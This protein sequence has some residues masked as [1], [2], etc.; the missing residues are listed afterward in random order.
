MARDGV[1][2]P[3]LRVHVQE[4]ARVGVSEPDRRPLRP[5]LAGHRLHDPVVATVG[6]LREAAHL[7]AVCEGAPVEVRVEEPLRVDVL[8]TD[9]VPAADRPPRWTADR[10]T[11][12]P[13]D[14]AS[15][16]PISVGYTLSC[17]GVMM[18]VMVCSVFS[19]C[20]IVSSEPTWECGDH[21]LSTAGPVLH[22]LREQ[23]GLGGHVSQLHDR[24]ASDHGGGAT[25]IVGAL[26]R[27]QGKQEQEQE[28]NQQGCCISRCCHCR[29]C[30]CR[31]SRCRHHCRSRAVFGFVLFGRAAETP[32]PPLVLDSLSTE[33][34]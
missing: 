30:R 8:Q 14:G 2:V 29:C 28:E 5:P 6:P 22:L 7:L 23:H 25:A 15:N 21:L 1:P 10:G 31:Y 13:V 20:A 12:L 27:R 4:L 34:Q 17:V 19:V 26:H 16:V 18:S 11:R 9:G 33:N 24:P 3:G 32:V